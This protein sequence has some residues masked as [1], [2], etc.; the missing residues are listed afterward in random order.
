MSLS[1]KN[2]SHWRAEAEELGK[3][4]LPLKDRAE[5]FVDLRR[6]KVELKPDTGHIRTVQAEADGDLD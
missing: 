5:N 4:L 2:L 6:T 3:E 1:S